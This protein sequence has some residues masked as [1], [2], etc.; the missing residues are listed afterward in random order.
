M[1]DALLLNVNAQNRGE[2]HRMYNMLR[3]GA[4][5]II[6]LVSKEPIQHGWNRTLH[7]PGNIVLRIRRKR[8]RVINQEVRVKLHGRRP[9]VQPQ[10]SLFHIRSP[11]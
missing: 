1:P 7:L 3:E 8:P 5:F 11:M 2:Y 10:R 9:R 6:I 4:A